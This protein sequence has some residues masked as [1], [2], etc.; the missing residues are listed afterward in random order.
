MH[1]L[2]ESG[3]Q[4][5]DRPAGVT[6]VWLTQDGPLLFEQAQIAE[7]GRRRRSAGKA[8][9]A[10]PD[11][12]M[13]FLR[14][15]KLKK[16]V[17]GRII[18]L[19][20]FQARSPLCLKTQKETGEA[21]ARGRPSA[22]AS[23]EHALVIRPRKLADVLIFVIPSSQRCIGRVCAVLIVSHARTPGFSPRRRV[24]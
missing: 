19:Q 11:R 3:R 16:D 1:L 12:I 23:I 22:A 7:S 4:A 5:N 24:Y 2:R 8:Y 6:F 18:E 14:Y 13:F 21:A 10:D 17:P 15:E 20:S 9:I